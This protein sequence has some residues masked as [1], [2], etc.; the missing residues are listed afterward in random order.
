MCPRGGK[1][2]AARGQ[3]GWGGGGAQGRGPRLYYASSG[4]ALQPLSPSRRIA[5]L[6]VGFSHGGGVATSAV[7][8]RCRR[9]GSCRLTPEGERRCAGNWS[10]GGQLPASGDARLERR[11][12][13]R[14]EGG[15]GAAEGGSGLAGEAAALEVK[16]A[17]PGGLE[18]ERKADWALNPGYIHVKALSPRLS[19][20]ASL[21]DAYLYP[22]SSRGCLG[23]G[24]G[25]GEPDLF[26]VLFPATQMLMRE[27]G[28]SS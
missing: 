23:G 28:Q 22:S 1:L 24:V 18:P 26:S 8:R 14:A 9:C 2:S 25:S 12:A 3:L 7:S 21:T 15:S 6:V 20:A 11:S 27:T 5:A 19:V 4:T 13:G 10:C 16:D 17:G